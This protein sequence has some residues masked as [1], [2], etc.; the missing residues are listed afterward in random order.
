MK[1]RTGYKTLNQV[2]GDGR[3][4]SAYEDENGVWIELAPGYNFEG[5]SAIR[6]DTAR[7]A[8]ADMARVE[9]G[10]PDGWADAA[11]AS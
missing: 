7:D 5:C 11:T 10:A 4:A 1:N 6:R 8:L 9:E 3:V 2:E